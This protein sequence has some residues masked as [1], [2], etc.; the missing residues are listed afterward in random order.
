MKVVAKI[1]FSSRFRDSDQRSRNPPRTLVNFN[2]H[3]HLLQSLAR[4]LSSFIS[5]YIYYKVM[6]PE[7][8]ASS[9]FAVS[10][11]KWIKRRRKLTAAKFNGEAGTGAVGN[12]DQI[13]IIIECNDLAETRSNENDVITSWWTESTC[14]RGALYNVLLFRRL[15]ISLFF[16]S[17]G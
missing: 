14:V 10:L 2:F 7:N 9:A 13:R 12:L 17:F 5:I 8:F 4:S 15:C 16:S 11:S 6:R 3:S 1:P